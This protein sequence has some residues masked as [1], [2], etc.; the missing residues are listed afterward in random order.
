MQEGV[1]EVET[2]EEE[3]VIDTSGEEY[4]KEIKQTIKGTK[5]ALI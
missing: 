2:I 4:M 1:I 3:I 5:K